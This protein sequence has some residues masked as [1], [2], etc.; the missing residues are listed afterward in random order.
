[1]T[2]DGNDRLSCD[3]NGDGCSNGGD[4]DDDYDDDG[5]GE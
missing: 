2:P 4:G 3:D 5:T 1:M